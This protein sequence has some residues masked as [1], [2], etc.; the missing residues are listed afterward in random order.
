MPPKLQIWGGTSDSSR[1]LLDWY[2]PSHFIHGLIFYA[3][4][5]NIIISIAIEAAWEVLEN[6]P[7]VVNRYRQTGSATYEGDTFI[8]SLSD[9]VCCATGFWFALVMPWW[10]SVATIIFWELTTLYFVRDN[11]T[12]NI[13]TLIHPSERIKAWQQQAS[14]WTGK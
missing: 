2:S 14:N 9:V 6:T 11:L 10:A 1:M 5:V 3:L 12:L 13:I 7:L 8:N 4:T